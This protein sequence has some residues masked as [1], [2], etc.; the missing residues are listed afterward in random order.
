MAKPV[1][2]SQ[3]VSIGELLLSGTFAPAKVQRDY[4]W[5]KPQQLAL[6]EDLIG[7]FQEFGFD[8]DKEETDHD[9]ASG[10]ADGE[11]PFFL[12]ER[13]P[14]IDA[15][16]PFHFLGG[17][18]LRPGEQNFEI[19]DGLQRLTTLL[20]LFAVLRDLVGPKNSKDVI[21]PLLATDGGALRLDM[22]MKHDT[23][24]ADV[25]TPGRTARRYRPLNGITEGGVR[26]RDCVGVMR[27]K[28]RDW[29]EAR[30]LAF[31][32]FV[33]DQV[34]VS[35]IHI[36]DRRLA[37]RT[38]VSIN[39]GGV[40]LKPEEILKGQLIDLAQTAPPGTE[41]PEARILF[42]WQLLH[43]EFGKKGFDEFLRSVDFLERRA[44]QSQDYSIQLME[45]IR[46]RYAGAEGFKW[47]TDRLLQY[48][49]AFKW[50][51]EGANEEIA[52]GVHASLRRL[53]MLKWDQWRAFAMLLK[54]KSRPHDLDKRIDV[55]DRMCFA[56]TL[57]KE[58]GRRCAEL[59]GRRLER[60]AKG[61]FGRN[62]GFTFKESQIKRIRRTLDSPLG[63]TRRGTIMRWLEAAQHGDRVPSYLADAKSSVEHVYPRNPGANWTSFEKNLDIELANTLLDMSGNLC[64]LPQDE[65]GNAP[66]DDKRKAYAKL[67]GC[68]FANEIAAAR[69][70]TPDA[71]RARTEKLR[72]WTLK[73]LDLDVV[74]DDARLR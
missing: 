73:L 54:I 48:R 38:F 13:N 37:G 64:V 14:E 74:P 49:A 3:V 15:G 6:A 29:N 71:I 47:A 67:R 60:F 40:P 22:A 16:A 59:L 53:H 28:L 4:C 19:Y 61:A 1:V 11:T 32:G 8:P 39:S 20:V 17:I 72:D 7:A 35:A 9:D 42:V 2:R 31:A 52:T 57:T 26:L 63:D 24:K 12:A 25:L 46:R 21:T 41:D 50:V 30:L 10:D 56:L 43:D 70:W 44:R 23:L 58:D 34:L 45:H 68:R 51:N 69:Q 55:L 5:N 33:R 62:G 27:E 18:V 36:S 66:F 65:L